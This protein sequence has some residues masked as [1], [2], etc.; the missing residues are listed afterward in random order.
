MAPCKPWHEPYPSLRYGIGFAK[1]LA[2]YSPFK[3]KG[4]LIVVAIEIPLSRAR[5]YGCFNTLGALLSGCHYDKGTYYLVDNGSICFLENP[6]RG[7]QNRHRY[8]KTLTT[9]TPNGDLFF[10]ENSP[11]WPRGLQHGLR[12]QH[13]HNIDIDADID[14]YI[15]IYI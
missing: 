9:R 12:L 5:V 6:S 14:I 15:N 13:I 2:A 7:P 8:E 1:A 11:A 10:L 4:I 3:W